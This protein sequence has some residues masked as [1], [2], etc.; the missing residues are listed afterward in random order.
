M[1]MLT[2][3]RKQQLEAVPKGPGLRDEYERGQYL[4]SQG[5][6]RESLL[7]QFCKLEGPAGNS[8]AYLDG[9]ERTFGKKE[10]RADG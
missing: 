8:R 4:K 9:W 2:E 1:P 7:K 3:K 5:R 6:K 10:E